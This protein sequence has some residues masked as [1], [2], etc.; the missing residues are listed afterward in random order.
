[1]A[2]S[3][4]SDIVFDVAKAAD[5][6]GYAE[7]AARLRRGAGAATDMAAGG[8]GFER[9]FDGL[10]RSDLRVLSDGQ[11][12]L[13]ARANNQILFAGASL[14][15]A[16]DRTY[17]NFEAMALTSFVE[18]MLPGDAESVFGSGT[19]GNVWRSM[20]AQHIA[21]EVADAGGIGI[22]DS[23]RSAAELRGRE[24]TVAGG[25]P[26]PLVDAAPAIGSEASAVL[27]SSKLT[28]VLSRLGGAFG[29]ISLA[30]VE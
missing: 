25:D 2:I 18:T 27:G 28:N 11:A 29:G 10:V 5:P 22:A 1:M 19:A 13:T 7:A 8:A 26:M 16:R 24:T 4:P 3:P 14:P 30:S 12:G 20:L 23:L 9:T 15:D 6:L 17:R 21:D